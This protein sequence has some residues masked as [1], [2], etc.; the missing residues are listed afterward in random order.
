MF[1]ILSMAIEHENM[2]GFWI[3]LINDFA[4]I[5]TVVFIIEMILKLIAFG[6][7]YFNYGWNKFDFFVVCAAIFDIILN[8]LNS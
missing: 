1:N 8:N 6:G 3:L 5:F 2:N 7:S 4:T